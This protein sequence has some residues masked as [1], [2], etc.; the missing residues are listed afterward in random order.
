M[1]S[2]T[3]SAIEKGGVDVKRDHVKVTEIKIELR[4]GV[5]GQ[6]GRLFCGFVARLRARC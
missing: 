3:K 1:E 5:G 6:I 4:F 2:L